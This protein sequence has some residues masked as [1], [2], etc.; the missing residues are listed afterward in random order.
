M[1]T[2]AFPPA[3]V[4]TLFAASPSHR[5]WRDSSP[6]A[7]FPS[8]QQH[9][10]PCRRFVVSH[11][12]NR[13]F[14]LLVNA[15]KAVASSPPI[16]ALPLAVVLVQHPARALRGGARWSP[17]SGRVAQSRQSQLPGRA[18]STHRSDC[19]EDSALA[20]CSIPCPRG[21]VRLTRR[22]SGPGCYLVLRECVQLA[23]RRL[24]VARG[25][26]AA[27]RQR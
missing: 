25:S 12:A 16:R 18:A 22:C 14:L 7:P 26:R 27:E 23:T 13:G 20:A 11:S 5:S 8:R 15:T 10:S 4:A 3:P 9:P 6:S 1:I 17:P 2:T 24:P 19:V 21:S